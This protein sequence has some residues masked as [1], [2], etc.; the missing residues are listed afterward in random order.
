MKKSSLPRQQLEIENAELRNRLEEAEET[1]RA[2]RGGEVDAFVVTEAENTRIVPLEGADDPYY[3]M[4][5]AMNEGAVSLIL[6]GTIFFCNPCFSEMVKTAPE[7]LIGSLFQNLVAPDEQSAFAMLLTATKKGAVREEFHLQTTMGGHISVQLSVRQMEMEG[8]SI[9][10]TDLTERKRAEQALHESEENFRALVE[11]ASDLIAVLNQDGTL[12]YVNP[13]IKQVLGYTV[14]EVTSKSIYEFFHPEDIPHVMQAVAYRLENSDVS[15]G[16]MEIRARHADGT[17]RILEGQG[18]NLLANQSVRGIVLN[19]HNITERIQREREMEAIITVSGALRLA[20]TL[21]EMLPVL[22]D[23]TLEV[24]SATQGAIW[25][26]DPMKDEMHTVVTRGWAELA[27]PPEKPGEGINGLVFATGLPYISREINLDLKL[28]ENVRR[29]IPPGIGGA[30]IPIRSRDSVIGTF[31]VNVA[32]P[33]EITPREVSLLTT[34]S[35]IAGNAIQRS[36]L[37]ERTQRDAQHFAA[38]HAIDVSINTSNDLNSTLNMLLEDVIRLLKVSAADVLLFNS[39]T[40]MLEYSA[41][42]GFH[43]GAIKKSQLRLGEGAA[44]RVALEGRTLIIPDLR[45]VE[46][47]FARNDLLTGEEFVSYYGVPLI[48]KGKI[49]G[50]LEIFNRSPLT[51]DAD[52]LDFMEMLASQ[53]AIAI[54]SATLFQDLQRSNVELLQAYDTTIEGW[55]RAVDLRDHETEGHSQRVTELTL[56]LARAQGLSDE[57]IACV[58]RGALLHDIG[59]MGVPDGIL[60]KPGPLTDEEW[61]IMRRHPLYAFDLLSPVEF[62]RPALDIPYCHHEKWDGTGYPRGLKG[63]QI[64]MAARLFAVVDVWDAL[65]SDRPYRKAWSE[66]KALEYIQSLSGTYF[67]PKATELFLKMMERDGQNSSLNE[68]L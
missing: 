54:S 28:P 25:L 53:A 48:T 34:L 64:P 23:K 58:R 11:N 10:V 26:Y 2:I 1:L 7:K 67:D 50:L 4:V 46:S 17:W 32:L 27:T 31:N 63:E 52:W 66:E 56:Q 62:L 49:I 40:L 38:L 3:A 43:S 19:F 55:S 18:G 59:K 21:D 60:L 42:K 39:S 6:D 14:A 45:T 51:P 24:M 36:R 16:I 30:T 13:A 65:R 33:R 61:V 12:R 15:A 22:L 37:H 41:G 68:D 44:E 5:E 20:D 29:C 9:V 35:E 8:L 57:E 47:E